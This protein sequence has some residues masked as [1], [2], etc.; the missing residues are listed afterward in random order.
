MLF[1]T[2]KCQFSGGAWGFLVKGMKIIEVPL[3][4]AKAVP[5]NIFPKCAN[6]RELTVL[7]YQIQ[8]FSQNLTTIARSHY[9]E[10]SL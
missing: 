5:A 9:P 8:P 7:Q 6:Y 1:Y 4:E 3:I 2:E 10:A